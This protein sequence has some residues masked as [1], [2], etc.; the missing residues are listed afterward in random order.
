MSIVALIL[1]LLGIFYI[2]GAIF[3]F[4]IM[5]EGNFKTK[6]IMEKLGRK[7]HKILLVVLG[8]IL[9]VLAFILR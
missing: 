6:W 7:N 2:V 5:F 1:L 8:C 4:P 9:L 3:E